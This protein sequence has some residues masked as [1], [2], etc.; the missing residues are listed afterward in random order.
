LSKKAEC[1]RN[2]GSLKKYFNEEKGVNSRLD[3]FQAA[4]L[5]LKLKCLKGWIRERRKI[6]IL[7]STFLKGVEEIII[8]ETVD[9]ATHVYHQ[10]VIKTKERDRLQEFLLKN[11]ISTLIHYPIPPHLQKAYKDLNFKKGSFPIAEEL[12]RIVLSLP[13]YPGL[14]ETEI[15]YICKT[16]KNFF[17]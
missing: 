10:Y 8:P 9:G 6:A 11:G 3:E 2:Y 16:I 17:K 1:L 12:S 15:N 14:K 7:Y 4:I 13:I 5:S